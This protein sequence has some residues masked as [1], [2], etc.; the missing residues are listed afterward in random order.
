MQQTEHP[1]PRFQNPYTISEDIANSVTH[2]IGV[3]LAIAGL[4]LLVVLAVLEGDP[5]RVVA[6]SIYGASLIFLYLASTIYHSLLN[7]DVKRIMQKVDHSAVYILIAG[8]YTPF[9]LISLRDTGLG[10]VLF[11]VVW[12]LAVVGILF[13]AVFI[14]RYEVIATIAY[15]AMGWMCVLVW[16]QMVAH[17][18]P[19]GVAWLVA[20][21]IVYTL[22]V[23]FYAWQKLPYNHTIWHLFVLGG[24]ICHFVSVAH[25]VPTT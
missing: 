17:V 9:L 21:G 5:W 12:G 11:G 2:G 4:I 16:Q 3:G 22:G 7:I 23:L 6:F 10:W 14:N 24:S 15:V 25:L 20:G 8:T 18:P 19:G 1:A 13:K